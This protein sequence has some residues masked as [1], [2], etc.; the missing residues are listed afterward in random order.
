MAISLSP[1][2][3]FGL[4]IAT[5]VAIL[6]SAV[7]FLWNQKRKS[8]QLKVQ[9]L[10]T[11]VRNVAT[12]HIQQALHTL[13]RKFILEIVKTLNWP[14]NMCKG[15]YDEIEQRFM[16]NETLASQLL[17]RF[18]EANDQ[19]S[20]FSDEV[21]AYK[22][23]IY[24]LLDTLGNGQREIQTFKDQLSELLRLFNDINRSGLP[25]ARELERVLAFC[26]RHPYEDL[27]EEQ[28]QKLM[29]LSASVMLDKDY[30]YWVN[31]FIPDAEESVYWGADSQQRDQV[32]VSALK[33]FVAHAYEKP[34]RLR[35]Q[36]FDSV[37]MRYQDGRIM[38]KKFLIM[39]AAVNHTLLLGAG[40]EANGKGPLEIAQ[41]YEGE[42]YFDLGRTVR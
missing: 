33:N 14:S 26:A 38:C 7:T 19:L 35:A 12:E 5:S 27:T 30:A 24:P 15:S 2:V 10:D 11:S 16:R 31:S 23:Q 28:T 39:L 1:S 4:D 21:E 3:Q 29:E 17:D 25:L 6:A 34:N 18:S 40:S 36:V 32:R 37:Y 20:N 13:S 9:Q 22:Y 8:D 42:A 41:R